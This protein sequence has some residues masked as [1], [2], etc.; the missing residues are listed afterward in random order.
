MHRKGY[1]QAYVIIKIINNKTTHNRHTYDSNPSPFN[2]T[3]YSQLL[4]II[5]F[6]IIQITLKSHKGCHYPHLLIN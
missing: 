5:L 3:N 2:I 1:D 4:E 6:D